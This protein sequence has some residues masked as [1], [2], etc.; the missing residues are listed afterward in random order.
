M[1]QRFQ[2]NSEQ[3]SLNHRVLQGER[4]NTAPTLWP[5]H[6]ID[7]A[8]PMLLLGIN[9]RLVSQHSD[10]HSNKMVS[11]CQIACVTRQWPLH[12][13]QFYQLGGS[14]RT[15]SYTS[16]TRCNPKKT[17]PGWWF[18]LPLK[19]I[20]P[21]E[22]FSHIS[23]ENKTSLKPPNQSSILR[24][25]PQQSGSTSSAG[26]ATLGYDA[27]HDPLAR[28]HTCEIRGASH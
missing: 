28:A 24:V 3:P 15:P 19:N 7:C 20:R 17:I 22:G 12:K 5:T 25:P 21:W 13:L 23:W 1:T 9:Y 26:G 14:L 18:Q 27:I 11:T 10:H 4:V 8:R 6:A 16:Q 2:L